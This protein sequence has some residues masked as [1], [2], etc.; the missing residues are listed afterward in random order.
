MKLAT[1]IFQATS[2][3][4]SISITDLHLTIDNTVW[5][6]C[7]KLTCRGPT[8]PVQCILV[9]PLNK[10]TVFICL[11][12]LWTCSQILVVIIKELSFIFFTKQ[13]DC[14]FMLSFTLEVELAASVGN[15]TFKVKLLDFNH[16]NQS[17]AL[18]VWSSSYNL[19]L[20]RRFSMQSSGIY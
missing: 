20:V 3:R 8:K 14:C 6:R 13:H 9:L 7:P 2:S 11:R 12:L 15:H 18:N 4:M 16:H 19:A 1:W 10:L 17:I 5:H